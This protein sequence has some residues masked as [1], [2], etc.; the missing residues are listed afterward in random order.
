MG[1]NIGVGG[2]EQLF[3][4]GNGEVL[5]DI[6]KF[7]A[8]VVALTGVTLGILVGQHRPLGLKHP[9]AGVVLGGNKLNMLLL[10]QVLGAHR[11]PEIRVKG[12]NGVGALFQEARGLGCGL[13]HSHCP[14]LKGSL[15]VG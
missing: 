12:R 13:V 6:N 1:L 5:G 7:A 9:G 3:R 8:P 4:P 10:P 11:L 2:T 14:E 15:W